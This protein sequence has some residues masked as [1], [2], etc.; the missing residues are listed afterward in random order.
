MKDEKCLRCV[1]ETYST[2]CFSLGGPQECGARRTKPST[3]W[4]CPAARL[5]NVQGAS[6]KMLHARVGKALHAKIGVLCASWGGLGTMA[7]EWDGLCRAS[8][9]TPG[10]LIW[11]C[12]TR[13]CADVPSSSRL[14]QL[15]GSASDH[16]TMNSHSMSFFRSRLAITRVG[17]LLAAACSACW[18]AA[19]GSAFCATLVSKDTRVTLS[20]DREH[21]APIP[22]QTLGNSH[23]DH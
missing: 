5:A 10:L 1:K 6:P 9:A 17:H 13:F 11:N 22:I 16:S 3:C 4:A 7:S 14:N 12:V 20:S 8:G 2:H 15:E 23:H 18:L 19:V 21:S